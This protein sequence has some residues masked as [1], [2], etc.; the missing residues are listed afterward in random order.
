M[1][2]CIGYP[3]LSPNKKKYHSSDSVPDSVW[4][5]AFA[6]FFVSVLSAVF[7]SV[8]GVLKGPTQKR[9]GVNTYTPFETDSNGVKRSGTG[10]NGYY[11][12][13]P[14][15]P[16]YMKE[17]AKRALGKGTGIM[18]GSTRYDAGTSKRGKRNIFATAYRRVNDA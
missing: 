13:L 10:N 2:S 4:T 11:P 17:R 7:D 16:V 12:Y 9:T 14:V 8:W 6:V 1:H 18:F 3:A 5:L 15:L